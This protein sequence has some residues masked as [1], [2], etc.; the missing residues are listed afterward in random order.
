MKI[1]S[2]P[3]GH[4]YNQEVNKF[5]LS[6]DN[7][8]S[9]TI[10]ELGGIINHLYVPNIKGEQADVVLGFHTVQGYVE[11]DS[12][13]FGA[14][15]GRVA[16][17]IEGA[18]YWLNGET[19]RLNGNAYDGRHCVHGG[20]FGYHRRV[21]QHVESQQSDEQVSITLRLIDESGEEGFVHKVV[22]HATYT[23]TKQNALELTFRAHATGPTPIS[24]TAHSYFNLFGHQSGSIEDH[25]LTVFATR[26]L[27]Q[28]EDRIPSGRRLN[29]DQSMLDFRNRTLLAEGIAAGNEVNHSYV[30]DEQVEQ[31]KMHKMACLTGAGRSLT[32][33]SNERTLHVYNGHNLSGLQGKNGAVYARYA[34]ICLEPKGYVN[35]VNEPA[36]PCT[37]IDADTEYEHKILYEFGLI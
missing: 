32:V 10:L 16:N 12:H 7:G 27:E 37:I 25:Q 21:W 1:E 28:K 14:L 20:R 18:K 22:V 24:T 36:F 2:L 5:V 31:D 8:M 4:F 26:Y 34:G 17:R 19:V 3:F 6:N 23:L 15:I 29:I 35:A 30:F 9:V 13:Y 11:H 33:Y